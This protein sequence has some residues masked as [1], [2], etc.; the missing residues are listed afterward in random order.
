MCHIFLTA[1]HLAWT[2]AF[3]P[4]LEACMI[5]FGTMRTRSLGGG[6][7]SSPAHVS[8][9]LSGFSNGDLL[10]ISGRQSMESIA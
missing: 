5:I 4:P 3:F 8:S 6:C 1:I 10:S 9:V 2:I 7:Q